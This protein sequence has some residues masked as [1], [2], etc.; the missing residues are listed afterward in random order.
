MAK[1]LATIIQFAIILSSSQNNMKK[2]FSAAIAIIIF[3]CCEKVT[4]YPDHLIQFDSTIVLGHHGVGSMYRENTYDGCVASLAI[5]DGVEVDIQV[6]KDRTIWLSH[7][8]A[9]EFCDH[10]GYCFAET[11]DEEIESIDSCNGED[12][13]YTKLEEV[14]KYMDENNIRKYVS[15]DI[16]GWDPCSGNSLNIEAIMR[17]EVELVIALGDK[18]HLTKYLDFENQLASV[19]LW[20]KEKNDT[21]GTYIYSFG[22][23]EKG[24]L[25][26]L[27]NGFTGISFKSHYVDE[28]DLNKMSLLHKKGLRLIA[29][30]IPDTTYAN[31]LKS[32]QVD[33]LEADL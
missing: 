3:S 8:S 21:V 12:I 32:I 33:F 30:N 23:Y 19:L 18:Y 26:A 24:M 14:F 16:K 10:T 20:A 29:W 2:T 17:L 9:V 27:K 5:A 1:R 25:V 28:L 4:Y 6:S 7:T 22:D 31:Y 13:S 11:S 15:I